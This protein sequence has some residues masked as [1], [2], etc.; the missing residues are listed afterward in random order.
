MVEVLVIEIGKVVMI[1][2]ESGE[3]YGTQHGNP[4]MERILMAQVREAVDEELGWRFRVDSRCEE[5]LSQLVELFDKADRDKA[6]SLD[7]A[8]LAGIL[9]Q[10]YTEAE[11]V[12]HRAYGMTG[13][14]YMLTTIVLL[15]CRR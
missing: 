7:A 1:D 10:M 9:F 12:C 2:E 14:T 5:A 4:E 6:G 8:K 3:P 11:V 15:L 13:D